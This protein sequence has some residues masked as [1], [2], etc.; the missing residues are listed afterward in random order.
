MYV[1]PVWAI[2]SGGVTGSSVD[3]QLP[4]STGAAVTWT[5]ETRSG[6]TLVSSVT[7]SS[8]S[9]RTTVTG[10][11]PN[12]VYTVSATGSGGETTEPIIF[13]TRPI[14]GQPTGETDNSCVKLTDFV[15]FLLP[16]NTKV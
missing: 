7:A 15:I 1:V 6:R 5:I 2:V 8:S 11:Q 13:A 12:T 10:L 9:Q 4:R 14:D 16:F 3:L